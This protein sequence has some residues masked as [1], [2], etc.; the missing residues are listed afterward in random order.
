MKF[1]KLITTRGTVHTVFFDCHY[2]DSYIDFSET[3]RL[4]IYHTLMHVICSYKWHKSE[5]LS[6]SSKPYIIWMNFESDMAKFPEGEY[7]VYK[8]KQRRQAIKT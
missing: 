7:Q 8:D 3:L 6:V 1:L 4:R 5:C 2:A